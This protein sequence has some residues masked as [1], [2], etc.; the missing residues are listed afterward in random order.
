[1]SLGERRIIEQAEA[2]VNQKEAGF[3]GQLLGLL[4]RTKKNGIIQEEINAETT[5]LDPKGKWDQDEAFAGTGKYTSG[6]TDR[7][8]PRLNQ[9]KSEDWA[10]TGE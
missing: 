4:G 5:R 1:M 3:L 10:K 2:V 9:I 8:K 7:Q 6:R